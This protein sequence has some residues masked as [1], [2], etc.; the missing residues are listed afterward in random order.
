M[1]PLQ[2]KKD[3]L[4]ICTTQI[5]NVATIATQKKICCDFARHKLGMLR[6]LQPKKDM[7]R[8]FT[9]QIRYVATIATQKRYVANLHDTNPKKICCEFARHKLG[10]LRPLQPKKDKLR[11]CTTQ[12]RY[13]ATIATQ[14]RYCC[15]F[16][17]H[18]L[19]MLRPLQPKKDLLRLCTTQIRY[20]A[21]IATQKRYVATF[22]RH[23]LGMLRPLQPKKRYV[24]KLRDTN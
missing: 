3:M 13:V 4:R 5:R 7:L 10:M 1:R 17:R 18:K 8:L 14:K 21:T 6:P 11:L 22:A 12:I 16:A 24:A 9:T 2:P 20:V 23:K 19:G 15:D